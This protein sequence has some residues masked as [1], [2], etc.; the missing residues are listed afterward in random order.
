M[1]R[2]LAIV[3]MLYTSKFAL[4]AQKD[5]IIIDFFEKGT[6][7]VELDLMW[8]YKN[9]LEEYGNKGRIA[10]INVYEII[11]DTIIDNCKHQKIT[12]KG[13]PNN[14][15][16]RCFWSGSYYYVGMDDGILWQN[17]YKKTNYIMLYDFGRTFEKGGSIQYLNLDN[18]IST[19][20]V[21]SIDTIYFDNGYKGII[22]N[23]KF[24][25][26]LGHKSHPIYW[27]CENWNPESEGH[28]SLNRFLCFYYRGEIILQDDELMD[29]MLKSV[30]LT[31]SK[32]LP[33]TIKEQSES[34]AP[35]YDLTGRILD[36]VPEKGIYIQ[37]GKKKTVK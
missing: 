5:N 24:I 12:C 20:I 15:L 9:T 33:S 4:F 3:I 29:L 8:D 19:E 16:D 7:W 34:N 21:Q 18:S 27:S 11:G 26:G 23:D 6:R 25:Y 10:T 30:D 31:T 36:K 22:A 14:R 13:Y 35:I 1:N 28:H 17:S 37:G 32:I 2:L